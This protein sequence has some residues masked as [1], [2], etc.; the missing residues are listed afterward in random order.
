MQ[1]GVRFVGMF[2]Q[3]LDGVDG[4]EDE[5]RD[6]AALGLAFHVVHHRQDTR[7]GADDQALAFPGNLLFYRNRSVSKF[8]AEFLRGLLLTLAYIPTVDHHVVLIGNAV[9]S[10]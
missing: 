8:F 2:F 6:L 7:S 10:D 4:W 3:R 9:D 5:Q 1:D